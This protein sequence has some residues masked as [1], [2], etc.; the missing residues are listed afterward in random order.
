M[1]QAPHPSPTPFLIVFVIMPEVTRTPEHRFLNGSSYNH[2]LSI[3]LLSIKID[4]L[5]AC[6][7]RN[8]YLSNSLCY[9]IVNNKG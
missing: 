1:Q 9:V 6:Y 2:F 3:T 5:L 7:T 4:S 8:L